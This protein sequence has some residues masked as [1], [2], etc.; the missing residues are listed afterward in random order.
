MK[1]PVI[2]IGL[3][4]ADQLLVEEWIDGGHLKN[5][6]RLRAQGAYCRLTNFDHHRAELPWTTFLTG[7]RPQKTGFW[8]PYRF[9]EKNY[10]VR[11]AGSYDFSDC[12]PF[13]ALGQNY[14]VAVFDVPQ[15]RLSERVSGIQALAWGAHSPYAS[16]Q[17]S[18]PQLIEELTARYGS[19]PAFLK[20]YATLW[21]LAAL[22]RLKE[23]LKT[24][25][26]RRAAICR[27]LLGREEW[28]LFLT[29]FGE[30]HSA[31]HFFWH[32]SRKDHPLYSRFG[33]PANDPLLEIYQTIDEAVG[34]IIA[35]ASPRA[36]VMLFAAHG[37]E[38]N[39]MDLPSTLFLPELLYRY[40]FPG[41]QYMAVGRI[42]EPP[43]PPLQARKRGWTGEVWSLKQDSNP[44]RRFLRRVVPTPR[45]FQYAEKFF[46]P[47]FVPALYR[48][49]ESLAYN[50]PAMW[51]RL[52][53]PQMKAFA[54]P[55]FAEGYVRINARGR[56][57]AGIVDES[58][59]D[60]V[61]DEITEFLME[62][63]D[64]R[65]QKKMV[66]KIIRTRRAATDAD[67]NLPDADLIVCWNSIVSD[68]VDS[69]RLGRIGPAPFNRSG[70]HVDRGFILA[71][72]PDIAPS[73]LNS[74]GHALDIA[75][76]ILEMM[77]APVA[78]HLDG[79]P[80]IA[81]RE[82]MKD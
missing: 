78:E 20:D 22:D 71:A 54:L 53:W 15:T 24:G 57:R 74:T 55:S 62:L 73:S 25:I 18:P 30:T 48:R 28:D 29:A 13:Y 43:P 79:R 58:Q 42:D 64:A 82:S 26:R 77:G 63:K 47:A 51:H 69:P 66:R 4:S 34:E 75:P 10:S 11:E 14:R 67:A 8:S 36:R 2:A 68:V 65:T 6:S 16:T 21:N 80:L 33:S 61:C 7:C 1:N 52:R 50:Q 31:G 60:S 49:Q 19:H 72:G 40:S 59:Y 12:Q 39:T 46:G 5:I 27:D 37:M 41:K 44:L 3:D 56:E 23:N 35:A 17:S 70:S 38:S 45:V 76:T 32:L 81:L 9:D